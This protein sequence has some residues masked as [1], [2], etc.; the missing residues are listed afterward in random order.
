MATSDMEDLGDAVLKPGCTCNYKE[1]IN[2]YHNS[3]CPI[4]SPKDVLGERECSECHWIQPGT[5][6]IRH[7]STCSLYDKGGSGG[8]GGT[9]YP[10]NGHIHYSGVACR[11]CNDI[12]I[13][14]LSALAPKPCQGCA[15]QGSSVNLN[16]VE[17]T[18]PCILAPKPEKFSCAFNPLAPWREQIK[19]IES[20]TLH[21]DHGIKLSE[22][23]EKAV[24]E[25]A[26]PE[27]KYVP[28][29]GCGKPK[30]ECSMTFFT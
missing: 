30:T 13:A 20:C 5:G 14:T 25:E 19:A 15:H 2:K 3:S 24:K 10:F 1:G 4:A 12:A 17:H 16:Y 21:G 29:C 7:F 6:I 28:M 9:A 11:Q 22:F 8:A 18:P 27:K 26:K 23:V